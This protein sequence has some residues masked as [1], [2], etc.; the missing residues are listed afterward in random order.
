MTRGA[1]QFGEKS[2]V[3]AGSGADLQDPVTEPDVELL[4][5]RRDDTGRGSRAERISC[6]IAPGH[7]GVV[8]SVGS[9]G[10]HGG[11]EGMAGHRPHRGLDPVRCDDPAGE[12]EVH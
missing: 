2:R 6:G 7:H 3:I 10:R 5:H 4:Q 1:G 8:G 9:F 11:D 12:Q